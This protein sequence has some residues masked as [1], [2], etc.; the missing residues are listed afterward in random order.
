LR[1]VGPRHR[2]RR[3]R[4]ARSRTPAQVPPGDLSATET[5]SHGIAPNVASRR[6]Y[7]VVT[8]SRSL[9]VGTTTERWGK[10][11]ACDGFSGPGLIASF[12]RE[13]YS[14]RPPRCQGE[15]PSGMMEGAAKVG[16]N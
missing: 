8:L 13:A 10:P 7:S 3:A 5:T 14:R 11:A 2:T 4:R 12:M 1:A 15:V 6:L 16:Q 9:K